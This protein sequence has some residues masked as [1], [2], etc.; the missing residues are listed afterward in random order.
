LRFGAEREGERTSRPGVLVAWTAI[1]GALGIRRCIGFA[2]RAE[3]GFCVSIIVGEER[4][5]AL[6]RR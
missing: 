2:R 5:Q 4:E 1:G 6:E 3:I